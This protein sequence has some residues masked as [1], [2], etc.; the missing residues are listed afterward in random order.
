MFY[1]FYIMYIIII[2]SQLCLITYIF[3]KQKILRK[4]KSGGVR[5]Y[6]K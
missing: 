2:Y 4:K 6:K 3:L 5:G 1:S